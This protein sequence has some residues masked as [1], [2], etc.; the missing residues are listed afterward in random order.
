MLIGIFAF[1]ITPKKT[2][3]RW[4]AD[5]K[6]QSLANAAQHGNM[7]GIAG[8]H[9]NTDNLVT[10]TPFN[11][12]I[13]PLLLTAPAAISVYRGDMTASFYSLHHFYSELRGP[14]IA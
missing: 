1:S 14:P 8:Y 5:H 10:D 11:L 3:H 13:H 12:Y 9:C 2:I 6:D 4:I 7:V